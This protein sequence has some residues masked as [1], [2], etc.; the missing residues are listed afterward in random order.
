VIPPHL[1]GE[2]DI[3]E[4]PPQDSD[5]ALA[6]CNANGP[7]D[8]NADVRPDPPPSLEAGVIEDGAIL[9]SL[10]EAALVPSVEFLKV[11]STPSHRLRVTRHQE[12]PKSENDVFIDAPTSP[13]P[14]TPKRLRSAFNSSNQQIPSGNMAEEPKDR[15]FEASDVD[16][17]SMLRLVVE[18]D[19]RSLKR[20]DYRATTASP[21]KDRPKKEPLVLD[22]ITV[23]TPPSKSDGQQ[24]SRRARSSPLAIPISCPDEHTTPSP[25][26]NAREGRRKRKRSSSKRADVGSKK[27]R[28]REPL[29]L[30][31]LDQMPDN[32]LAPS[33]KGEQPHL[34][35]S[36]SY[37]R[38]RHCT[39]V[40]T[41]TEPIH[42]EIASSSV[43][44]FGPNSP[45]EDQQPFT[46]LPATGLAPP[47]SHP[48]TPMSDDQG[49]QS[50]I[51]L[52][53][54]AQNHRELHAEV[55]EAAAIM[56]EVEEAGI[57]EPVLE[58]AGAPGTV[59]GEKLEPVAREDKFQDL[60]DLLRGGLENLRSMKLS[61]GEVYKIED[62]FM[63]MKRELYEAERRGRE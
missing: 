4:K 35:D 19:A 39:S 5:G 23:K 56:I 44:Y 63:D 33:S 32:L 31:D 59:E 46:S 42:E 43:E 47:V 6:G 38:R 62:V 3:L 41:T 55:A 1:S 2:K 27:R 10:A 60:I 25:H 30:H 13:L 49:V 8:P 16:E 20:S 28:Q 26:N 21:E 11:P 18:V 12:T 58:G 9:P 37:R 54:E 61:R 29:H 22:C 50:Q 57:D 24:R 51:A 14:P 48:E 7:D 40:V 17:R 34:D 15:S 52:E 36:C 45:M 53:T